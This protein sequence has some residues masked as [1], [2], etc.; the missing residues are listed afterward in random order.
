[1]CMWIPTVQTCGCLR[2]NCIPSPRIFGTQSFQNRV[3]VLC[4]LVL[5]GSRKSGKTRKARKKGFVDGS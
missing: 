3:S 5:E 1:M 2:V 4:M